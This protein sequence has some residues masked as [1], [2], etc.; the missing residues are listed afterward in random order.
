MDHQSLAR[1]LLALLCGLQGAS[2]AVIDLNKTHAT[3]PGWMG[4][5]RFHVVWQTST[6]VVLSLL[7]IALVLMPGPSLNQ[8]FYVAAALAAAPMLGFF[9]A[10][11]AR[12]LY[13][14]TLSDPGGIPPILWRVRGTQL[15]VDL[16]LVAEI[17]GAISLAAIMAI[18]GWP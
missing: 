10:L 15:K 9:A 18:Y 12:R 2:T 13:H 7:E 17:A 14:G 3:H 4:H 6:V 1:V 16:N 8:R 11:V 5:A